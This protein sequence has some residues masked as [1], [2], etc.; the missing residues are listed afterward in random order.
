MNTALRRDPEARGAAGSQALPP[1]VLFDMDGTLVDTEP[2]WIEAER[3]LTEAHGVTWTHE[4]ALKLVGQQLIVSAGVLRAAGVPME[5]A[6]IVDWLVARVQGRLAD[7]VPWRAGVLPLLADLT[8]AGVPCAIV[9]MSYRT[10][11][12]A[13]AAGAPEGTFATIVAGDEVTHGKPDP[14]PYLT[15]ADRLGVAAADCVAVEDSPVGITSALASGAR[16]LGIEAVLPVE[17]RPGLSR[18]RSLD[19]AGLGLIARLA[20]GEVVDEY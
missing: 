8:A 11:A 17:A 15:A 2:Y 12:E 5:P 13:V 16:T 3:E 7:E 18:L 6:E 20:A 19:G 14:E 1:A 4:D 9:T 10:L